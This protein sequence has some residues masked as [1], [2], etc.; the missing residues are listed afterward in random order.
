L[1]GKSKRTLKNKFRAARFVLANVSKKNIFS[2][3]GLVPAPLAGKNQRTLKNC[4]RCALCPC[5]LLKQKYMQEIKKLQTEL[6]K[7][8]NI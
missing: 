8:K 4:P 1:A 3:R 2:F 7:N 6:K 5:K